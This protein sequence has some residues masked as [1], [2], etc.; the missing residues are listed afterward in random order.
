MNTLRS[1]S[2]LTFARPRREIR[3]KVYKREITATEGVGSLT[4]TEF[5]MVHPAK[6]ILL[7]QS[8]LLPSE[9][10]QQQGSRNSQLPSTRTTTPLHAIQHQSS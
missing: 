1:C 5:V 3:A 8:L 9:K 7:P 6:Q 4:R 10:P 2:P